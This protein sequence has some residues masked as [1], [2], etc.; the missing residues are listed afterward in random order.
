MSQVVSIC[1][2]CLGNIVRSPLAEGMFRE[3]VRKRGVERKYQVDSAGTSAWHVGE[4]PDWRMRRV[5]SRHGLNYDG[6]ARQFHP[7]DIQAFDLIIAMDS[8][9]R[10]DLWSL[11][12]SQ[13]ERQKIHL[14]R[15]YDPHGGTEAPVPDPYYGGMDGFEDVYRIVTRSCES[16]LD[17]LEKDSQ[18]WEEQ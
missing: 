1:F 18:S 2:V 3:L 14:L 16:L 8:K 4:P 6:R 11:C 10:D 5:A 9:N 15:E 17:Q 13:E 12:T 7:E